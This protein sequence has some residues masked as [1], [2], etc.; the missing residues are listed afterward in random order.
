MTDAPDPRIGTTLEGRYRI[1]DR[2]AA[3]GMGVV[4]KGELTAIGKPVAVKFLHDALT[5]IPD[6][7]KRFGREAQA[8]SKLAHPNLVSVLDSGLDRGTPFL[9]PRGQGFWDG[10][11]V[12]M[13]SQPIEIG[14]ELYFYHGGSQIHHDWWCGPPEGIDHDD[15]ELR[16]WV[17][18]DAAVLHEV[19][20]RNVDHLRPRMPWIAAEPL[21]VA[22]RRD[23]IEKWELAW[24]AGGDAVFAIRR[25]GVALGACGLHRRLGPGGLEIGYWVDVDHQRQGIATA[26]TEALTN[27][28]FTVSDID[29]VEIH[30][31]VTNL[32]SARIPQKL[33]YVRLLD[34]VGVERALAPADIG[35][36][37]VWRVTR[38]DWATLSK[39]HR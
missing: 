25:D 10:Y 22:D 19:I 17:P 12:S 11:M 35:T 31:D 7:V 37:C 15:L 4:Y 9:A 24:R 36:D 3:G 28:A 14:D 27:L 1:S 21:V 26:A 18:D 6:V 29:R 20:I 33:G 8:M 5:L 23:L 32:A 13:T 2:L 34:L 39:E 16:R 30:H 38:V